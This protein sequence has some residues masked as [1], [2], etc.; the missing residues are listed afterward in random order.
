MRSH[1]FPPAALILLIAFI[2]LVNAV[3]LYWH[4]FF[5][6]WWLDIPM[7]F[8]GGLWLGL[9]VLSWYYCAPLPKKKDTS[10]LFVMTLAVSVSLTIGLGWELFELSAQTFIE[11]A[12][13]HNLADTLGD[14]TNDLLGAVVATWI[15]IRG[16]YNA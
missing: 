10:V 14:L 16:R 8:L 9:T 15:F 7:H 6:I 11:R 3:A 1:H 4:L 5:Y 12:T 13:V 2:A